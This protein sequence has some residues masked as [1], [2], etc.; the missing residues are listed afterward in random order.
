MSRAGPV[1]GSAI[2]VRSGCS[3]FMIRGRYGWDRAKARG[4]G[5]I[6]T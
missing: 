4:G 3:R 2:M 1:G 5:N 6:T